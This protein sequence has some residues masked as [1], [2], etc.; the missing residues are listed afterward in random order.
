MT[1][2]ILVVKIQEIPGDKP[3]DY[4]FLTGQNL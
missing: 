3:P 4:V 1:L 2:K